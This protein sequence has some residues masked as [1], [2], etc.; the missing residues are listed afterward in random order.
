MDVLGSESGWL[1]TEETGESHGVSVKSLICCL[2]GPAPVLA[3]DTWRPVL[4]AQ[5]PALM[6]RGS[7]EVEVDTT[8]KW[9]VTNDSAAQAITGN[10]NQL[11]R[12]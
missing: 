1:A 4:G 6:R 11:W 10:S 2:S 9:T 8:E 12:E 3:A 5:V 7:W